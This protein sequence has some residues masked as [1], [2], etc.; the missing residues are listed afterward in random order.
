MIKHI[1][2]GKWLFPLTDEL[3]AVMVR[4][5]KEIGEH[6]RIKGTRVFASKAELEK[7]VWKDRTGFI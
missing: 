5:G 4:E 1:I 7:Q 6:R 3:A 2:I